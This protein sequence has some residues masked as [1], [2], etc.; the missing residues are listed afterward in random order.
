MS[1]LPFVPLLF[2][3][4]VSYRQKQMSHFR[5]RVNADMKK[6]REWDMDNAKNSDEQLKAIQRDS[7]RQMLKFRAD[8]D[9]MD[10]IFKFWK[11]VSK[12]YPQEFLDGLHSELQKVAK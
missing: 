10:V 12:M 7:A 9:D 4:W 6:L 1:L 5:D 3:F 2:F 11:P 8:I